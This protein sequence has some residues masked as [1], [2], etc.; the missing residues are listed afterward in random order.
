MMTSALSYA[1]T[2]RS[3]PITSPTR[4][5]AKP[6]LRQM[7]LVE[8]VGVGRAHSLEQPPSPVHPRL[9]VRTAV[10]PSGRDVFERHVRQ[11]QMDEVQPR[12]PI[13]NRRHELREHSATA[14]SGPRRRRLARPAELRPL[15]DD[16]RQVLGESFGQNDVQPDEAEVGQ[17]RRDRVAGHRGVLFD[18]RGA[19]RA[20]GTASTR[21]SRSDARAP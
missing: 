20:A 19:D 14:A 13:V 21:R 16:R 1:P 18:T 7:P 10:A 5:S 15:T 11:H 3:R 17:E 6:D 12:G 2:S 9:V 4:R 8:R